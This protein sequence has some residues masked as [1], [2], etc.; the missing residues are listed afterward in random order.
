MIIGKLHKIE[1]EFMNSKGADYILT[2][3]DVCDIKEFMKLTIDNFVTAQWQIGEL[4]KEIKELKTLAGLK[5][6]G[7]E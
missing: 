5:V 6:I 7:E 3:T 1:K 4:Q 2:G